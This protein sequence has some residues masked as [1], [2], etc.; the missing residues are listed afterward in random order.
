MKKHGEVMYILMSYLILII[1]CP[2]SNL[3]IYNYKTFKNVIGNH[4]N[5]NMILSLSLTQDVASL[6]PLRNTHK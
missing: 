1:I 2:K 5:H 3:P 4:T 6:G